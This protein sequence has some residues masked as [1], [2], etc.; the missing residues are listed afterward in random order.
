[1]NFNPICLCNFDMFESLA[2][3]SHRTNSPL[4]LTEYIWTCN[5]LACTRYNSGKEWLLQIYEYANER[6]IKSWCG[7]TVSNLSFYPEYSKSSS[8]L[9][10]KSKSTLPALPEQSTHNT[11]TYHPERHAQTVKINHSVLFLLIQ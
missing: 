4:S 2:R 1:M 6:D 8:T 5:D 3:G 11:T 7:G 10:K 9:T